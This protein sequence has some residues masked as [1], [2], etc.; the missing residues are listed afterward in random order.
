MASKE[1][2]K[3]S[4]NEKQLNNES[5]V[6]TTCNLCLVKEQGEQIQ[7]TCIVAKVSPPSSVSI[8]KQ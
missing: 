5:Q 1:A 8:E 7:H 4:A 3:E 2:L 6:V